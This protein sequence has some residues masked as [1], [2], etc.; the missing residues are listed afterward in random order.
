M[1]SFR[2][3]SSLAGCSAPRMCFGPWRGRPSPLAACPAKPSSGASQ[4]LPSTSWRVALIN[5]K[6]RYARKSCCCF[7]HVAPCAH[8]RTRWVHSWSIVPSHSCSWTFAP[9][10]RLPRSQQTPLAS[11]TPQSTSQALPVPSQPPQ[12]SAHRLRRSATCSV[13]RAGKQPTLLPHAELELAA[14]MRPRGNIW[15]ERFQV[16]L[17]GAT[18]PLL[19]AG[20]QTDRLAREPPPPSLLLVQPPPPLKPASCPPTLRSRRPPDGH[21]PVRRWIA[22]RALCRHRSQPGLP[23]AQPHLP[24]KS[25]HLLPGS[26]R[27][28]RIKA[29]SRQT[30]WAEL[31]LT[32][33]QVRGVGGGAGCH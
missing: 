22:S 18:P 16:P 12:P 6:T 26:A 11:R 24:I 32:V 17:P 15:A 13:R 27:H 21:L 19:Q 33:H 7:Q 31:S 9:P 14:V 10:R 1:Q 8:S 2:N 28:D 29:R 23:Q 30:R 5:P 25:A 3:P 4:R 20:L